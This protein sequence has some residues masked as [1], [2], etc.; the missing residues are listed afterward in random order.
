MANKEL[1]DAERAE[2]QK[3]FDDVKE[4]KPAAA[5]LAGTGKTKMS[6][7]AFDAEYDTINSG[8]LDLTPEQLAAINERHVWTHAEDGDGQDWL[9]NGSFASN[10][11]VAAQTGLPLIFNRIGYWLSAKPWSDEHEPGDVH[12][13]W[14]GDL[15][16][17]D[18]DAEGDDDE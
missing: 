18:P 5:V 3:I 1:S 13:S 4:G 16:N 15:E 9:V 11:A 17:P 6:E 7:D 14:G 8:P 10:T 12:V 2:M